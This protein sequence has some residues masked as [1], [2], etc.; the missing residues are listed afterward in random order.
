[1]LDL[2]GPPSSEK[3][4]WRGVVSIFFVFFCNFLMRRMGWMGLEDEG[5]TGQKGV[6]PVLTER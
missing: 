5:G 3:K 4:G 2:A 1:M 6:F